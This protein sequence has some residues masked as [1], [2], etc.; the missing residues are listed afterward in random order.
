MDHAA[1]APTIAA[2]DLGTNNCR[3]LVAAIDATQPMG[4][5]VIDGFSR[6]TRLGEGTLASG[7]LSEQAMQRTLA[8]IK[9]CQHKIS[10]HK[11]RKMRAVATEACR[12]A[13][14]KHVF[15][16][17]VTKECGFDLEVID[18][19]EE[20]RL[21]MLACAPL[22]DGAAA[23]GLIFDIGG[24]ST[25]VIVLKK[26]AHQSELRDH[27]SLPVGVVSLTE[28]FGMDRVS[29]AQYQ[30]MVTRVRLPLADFSEKYDIV[31]KIAGREMQVAGCS[32]TITT[33]AAV[34]MNLWRY[35]RAMVDGTSLT[36]EQAMTQ[37]DR[38][39]VLDYRERLAIPSIGQ[40][41]ADLMLAGCAILEGL[42][43]ELGLQK[44]KVGDRGLRDGIL[45]ELAEGYAR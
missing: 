23:E 21:A 31:R 17:R 7:E 22:L 14:N 4:Y 39:K 24:G 33:M 11:A 6:M 29:P 26:N 16:N 30:E 38:V 37:I 42:I 9:E 3:L 25:E 44:F 2:I 36:A 8:A 35:S 32:G 45:A 12:L 5:R 28:E 18:T 10:V 40:D 43:K 19:A 20:A 41:R 27:I 1:P 15:Q 34:H 13:R